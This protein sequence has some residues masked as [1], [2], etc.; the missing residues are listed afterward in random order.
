MKTKQIALAVLLLVCMT[1]QRV[2]ANNVQVSSPTLTGDNPNGAP[3]Y[4][5]VQFNLSW[6][7]SWRDAGA[8]SPTANWDAVWLFV[9]YKDESGFYRHA[10]LSPVAANHNGQGFSITP[11]PDGKG[12]LIHRGSEGTGNVSLTNVQLRWNYGVDITQAISA[13]TVQV[14]A[15]EMVYVPQGAFFAGD[16]STN[17]ANQFSQGGT[18]TPFQITSEAQLELGGTVATNLSNRN[19][20]GGNGDDFSNTTT[21]VLPAAFPKGFAAFYCMKYEL[22]FGQ[23]AD[24]LNNLSAQQV[25]ALGGATVLSGARSATI[26]GTHP[27]LVANRPNQALEFNNTF[28]GMVYL[29]W[30]GLRMMSELEYEKASR[31]PLN[32]V[33]DE[34]AWGNIN[35]VEALALSGSENGSETITTAQANCNYNNAGSFLNG[36]GGSG[37]LRCGIFAQSGTGRT[38][39]GGSYYGIMELS[40]NVL[41]YFVSLRSAATRAYLAQHGTGNLAANGALLGAEA[42]NWNAVAG[43]S[44]QRGGYWAT[45][46]SGLDLRTSDRSG[47]ISVGAFR[48]ARTAP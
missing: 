24:F 36:D 1:F 28:R 27:N 43:Q 8:P 11:A 33:A 7:N 32:P 44:V 13:V 18:T 37:T 31:G 47:G 22:S 30:A 35:V 5:T 23:F 21:R 40:G 3:A 46:V 19:N 34:Y 6:N 29:A 25:T 42:A 16:G 4:T 39:S 12:V 41:E 14:F 17:V 45:V 10:T 38:Q 48:G 26:T 9:K 20:V 15:I 2:A